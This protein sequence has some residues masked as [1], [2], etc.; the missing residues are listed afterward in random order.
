MDIPWQ[1][2]IKPIDEYWTSA[3]VN[4]LVNVDFDKER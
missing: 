3:G 1:G 4:P 2:L